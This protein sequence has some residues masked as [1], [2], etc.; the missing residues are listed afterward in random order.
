MQEFG[1]DLGTANTVVCDAA[2][3]IVLDE[4]SVMLVRG[5]IARRGVVA[6]GQ[7]ACDLIGRSPEGVHA[8]R[9][10]A[11][12][13]ITDLDSARLYLRSV[14][15]RIAPRPWGR[16]RV[17]AAI[18]V[19]VGATALER[20]ALLEAADEAGI[21]R[22]CVIDEP[23]AGAVGCGIDPLERRAHLVVDVGGG[24]AEVTAFCFGGILA[25]RSC[26][27]AGDEMTLAVTHHLR[28]HHQLL[29]G[30]LTAEQVKI[31]ASTSDEPSVVAQGRDAGTGRPRLATIGLDELANVVQ[32]VIDGIIHTLAACLDELPP[33]A[34]G[35]ILA[36]GVALFGGGS[37]ARGF[38]DN[39]ERAFGFPV[40]LADRP[41]TCVAEG[42]AVSLRNPQLL[43]SY[44]RT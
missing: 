28:E 23:I 15:H 9:P 3:G 40:K 6:I 27:V 43:A 41:M 37:L 25:H 4:P 34:T 19:P 29:V 20:R 33:Q 30:E 38:G 17:R 18:G 7:E 13:V 42:A 39:L 26:R 24:T 22:A 14:L 5:H 36:D 31:R 8:I 12:G 32:P 44:A 1:I 21:H 10:L 2:A 35:D 11:D 16:G